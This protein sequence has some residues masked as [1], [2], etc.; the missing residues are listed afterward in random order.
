MV[1]AYGAEV[2]EWIA[3]QPWS[4]GNVGMVGNSYSGSS[5]LWVAA[6]RPAHLKAIVPTSVVDGYE[7]M[8][9]MGGML[10]PYLA[11]WETYTQNLHHSTGMEWRISRGDTECVNI[12]GSARQI[13]KNQYFDVMREHMFR[14][15]WWDSVDVTRADVV[16]QINV[17]TMI[18]GA[19]HDED[20]GAVRQ[21]AR[22]FRRLAPNLQHKR[23]LLTNGDHRAAS[24]WRGYPFIAEEQIKFLDRWVRDVKNGIENEPT[25][26]VF[27]EVSAAEGDPKNAVV[28]WTTSHANWPEPT[29]Q[30]RPYFLTADGGL[31]IEQASLSPKEGVRSYLYPTGVELNGNDQQFA[32]LP[33]RYGVLNYRTESVVEDMT[34]L[35]N[36]EMILFL[37]IDSGDDADVSITLKDISP[38]GIVLFLQFGLHRVSFQEID[39]AETNPEEVL[40]SFT[41][42]EKL[43]PKQIY[44][45]RMSLLSPLAHVVRK[46]HCLE[47]TIGAPN[48]T[49]HTLA[50]SI[51]A[52]SPSINRIHHSETHSSRIILPILPGAVAQ[53]PTPAS[54]TLLNQPSR[55]EDNF[56]AGGLQSINP[57]EF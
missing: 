20:G 16:G 37:S 48:P 25:V 31:S 53:A 44:E 6:E 33:Y 49:P 52:G 21:S 8:A 15:T 22:I 32:L 46:G 39:E 36:P 51:P 10:Q 1:G 55:K 27:W 17:P 30:R 7:T 9:Y 3:K 23:L 29:V 24:I 14:D 38:D 34:L 11:T 47:L 43:V 50:A 41:R 18:I 35:G 19:W 13:V 28:G 12:R 42:T 5:Q 2:V 4:D 40:H 54:G 26:K 57:N 56:I 45:V